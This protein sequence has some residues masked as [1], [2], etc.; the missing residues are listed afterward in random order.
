MLS[1]EGFARF[2]L[3]LTLAVTA[4][5]HRL[6][7]HWA[8]MVDDPSVPGLKCI[9]VFSYSYIAAMLAEVLFKGM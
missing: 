7:L 6:A 9:R 3:V 2:G 5:K 8:K 1:T 4:S